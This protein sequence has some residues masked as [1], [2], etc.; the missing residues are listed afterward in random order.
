[1]PSEGGS[2][3]LKP[4][5]EFK[6]AQNVKTSKDMERF[7][8]ERVAKFSCACINQR[9]NGTIY[10]GVGDNQVE[11]RHVAAQHFSVSP[12]SNRQNPYQ[13][14][15]FSIDA[16]LI[17]LFPMDIFFYGHIA[18]RTSLPVLQKVRKYRTWLRRRSA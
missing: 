15:T 8:I 16:F 4:A 6:G 2:F 5:I 9:C 11:A 3:D 12:F 13:L 14:H 17:D 1:M 18:H 10:F 7:F